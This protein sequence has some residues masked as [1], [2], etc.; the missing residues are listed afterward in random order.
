MN[1]RVVGAPTR[2][3]EGREKV[4]GAAR[5]TEDLRLPGMLH[6]R[7]VL[8]PH[9][10]ARIRRIP[11]EVALAVPGVEAV[12]TEADLPAG[13]GSRM[14]ARDEVRYAGQPVAAVLAESEAAAADGAER[15]A[16]AVEYEVLPAV[17]TPEDAMRDGAPLVAPEAEAEE[18][19]EE[20]G[21]ATLAAEE[22]A[23][24][25]PSN[26]ATRYRFTRGNIE[27]G[28][29]Q[30][31]VVIERT[32]RTSR[33]HQAHLEPHATAAAVD[34]ASGVVTVYSSTQGSFYVRGE[35]AEAL[36]VSEQQ[37]RVVPMT[38]GGGFGGKISLLE[39]LVAALAVAVRRPVRL[40]L[41]RREDFLLSNPG[42]EC[43][44]WLR[45]GAASDGA[46]VALQARIVFDAGCQPGAP[47][48]IA[49]ILLGGY[50]RA[51]HLDIES[52]EVLTHK[53]PNGAYRAPGAPQATFAIESQMDLM[54]QAL[55]MDPVEFRLRNAS[56]PGDPMPNGRPW[57][58]MGLDEVLRALRDH[59]RWTSRPREPGTG[60]GVAVGGW[61]GGVES[62][63]AC[64][65]ANPDGTF[66]V[67][68]G[69]V[70]LTGTATTFRAI[71]AEVLGVDPD[72]VRVVTAD[73]DH[74]PYAGMSAGS[75]TTYTVGAAVKM[76]AEDARRQIL[77]IAASE[78]E[79]RVD[80]LEIA[81]GQ[82]RVRGTP[83]KAIALAEIARKSMSFGARY[84]PI[85]GTGSIEAPRPS[86]GFAAHLARVRVDVETGQVRLLDY[87]VIQDVGFPIN[88]AAVE[89]QMRGGAAQGIGWGLLEA[90]IYDRQGTL[91]TTTFADYPIPRAADVPPTDVVMVQ[92]P[93]EAGPFGAKGVGEPPVVPGGAA[94][95]NAIADAT[96]VRI[97]ELP[98]TPERLLRALREAAG[99]ERDTGRGGL[100]SGR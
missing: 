50:Y 55:G 92:V 29:R 84:A 12:V 7:L 20:A 58:P 97:Y 86:P 75:K 26:V 21:H 15:L 33:L 91:L 1:P 10:H 9:P 94:I 24:T 74:A 63:S 46:L 40:V 81:D 71:A 5:Y 78:L 99:Q 51:P 19:D 36:G 34:P 18:D 67:I 100:R 43:T 42:P 17:L 85:F 59:P 49:A 96:G 52:L 53:A 57:P 44:I 79:A 28:F 76:A 3:I 39:P 54:A 82:V 89:G 48:S 16:A 90:M 66:Q 22:T 13:V 37:V 98:I 64:V 4:T 38:V 14:M 87:L 27:E 32:Y 62:A 35:V 31:A 23:A 60:Y 73:T 61:P 72:S 25:A 47:A 45:T 80:D 2:R 69:A 56:R 41:T 95:A 8:S 11:R 68:T 88:P 30:A 65:R 6:A 83:Q 77:S 93:S 70:D